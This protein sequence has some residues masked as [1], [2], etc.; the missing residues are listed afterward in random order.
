M[1]SM[2]SESGAMSQCVNGRQTC[3]TKVGS[4][5]WEIRNVGERGKSVVPSMMFECCFDCLL[6]SCG[7]YRERGVRE[8]EVSG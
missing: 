5:S 4:R 7:G 6:I 1:K 8:T 2:L 3:E